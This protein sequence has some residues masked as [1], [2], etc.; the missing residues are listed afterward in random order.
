[1]IKR[2][3]KICQKIF[4]TY[5]SRITGKSGHTGEFCSKACYSSIRNKNLVKNGEKTQYKKG[6][7]SF[8]KLHPELMPRG[9]NNHFWKGDEAGYRALHVWIK[10][11][12]G[13]PKKC[14]KC[15]KKPTA[16]RSIQW[17]NIDHQYKRDPKE[18]IALCSS[19][20]KLHDLN[21]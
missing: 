18:Y 5:P 11:I 10:R 20:H 3:C 7:I 19:C 8:S 4:Y 17:A 12:K 13:M 16:P 21:L 1:M 9:S 6:N 14:E 2:T 15:G